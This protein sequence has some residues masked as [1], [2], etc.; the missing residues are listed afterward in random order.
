M[1][2]LTRCAA[3]LLCGA[4]GVSSA[5]S[6]APAP[7]TDPVAA[8]IADPAR[9]PEDVARDAQR[10]PDLVLA[11]YEVTQGMTVVDF[12]AGGGYYTEF[13]SRVVG[14]AGRVYATRLAPERIADGRL[15]NVTAI[16]D[17]DWGL[18]PG[19]VDLVFTAQNY[20][21]LVARNI[22]RQP[23]LAL[24]LNV[25]KPGGTF[26]VSDHAAQDGSGARDANTLHRIDERLVRDEVTAAGFVFVADSDVLRHPADARQVHV[27]SGGIRGETDQFVLKFRKP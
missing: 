13:F 24:I 15:P 26:A 5:L 3:A 4:L 16:G 18:A 21:D 12:I 8:A 7:A 10:R 6:A 9:P 17:G 19:S 1:T 11:F 23:I 27:I 2:R 14:D 20:H 25:L 22:D